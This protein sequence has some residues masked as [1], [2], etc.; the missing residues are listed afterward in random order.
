MLIKYALYLLAAAL[1]MQNPNANTVQEPQASEFRALLEKAPKLQLQ[2]TELKAASLPDWGTTMVSWVTSDRGGLIYLLQRSD[3]ADPIVVMKRDGSV[4]RTFGKGLYTMPHAVRVDPQGNVWTTDAASSMVTKFSPDGKKLLEI[5]VGGQPSP[6]RNNFCGTTD[7]A[8]A[9]NGH[10]FIADGYANARILEYMPDGKK[11]REW[12]TAGKGPGQF[13][14]PHSIQVDEKGTIYV[15]DRENARIQRFDPAGKF[16]GEWPKYGKTYGMKLKPDALWISTQMRIEA[17]G[18][19]GWLMKL[20]RQTGQ[21]LGYIAVTGGVHGMEAFDDG[22]LILA[23][24]G[25]TQV[26]QFFRVQK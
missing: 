5:S 21:L 4:V 13:N 1:L 9:P 25:A 11:V 16:L 19:N 12:G 2:R 10:L 26:P 8:F 18:N 22:E 14:L 7:I 3:K 6:C 23:S 24:P 17:N 15:A 20:D